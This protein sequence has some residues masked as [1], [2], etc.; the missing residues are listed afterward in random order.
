MSYTQL[1]S[2]LA[3][4]KICFG[5][6]LRRSP[7]RLYVSFDGRQMDRLLIG[8]Y[9]FT[10]FILKSMQITCEWRKYYFHKQ[11]AFGNARFSSQMYDRLSVSYFLKFVVCYRFYAVFLTSKVILDYIS[12]QSQNNRKRPWLIQL[13]NFDSNTHHW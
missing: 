8:N 6:D 3:N 5:T 4:N 11:V 9:F 1:M 7:S 2:F 12:G 13:L 10:D